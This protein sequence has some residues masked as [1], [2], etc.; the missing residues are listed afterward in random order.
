MEPPPA[1]GVR[2][3]IVFAACD[4]DMRGSVARLL[5][6]EYELEAVSDGQQ[7]LAAIDRR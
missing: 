1:G 3:R 4:Q 7:A 2:P 5:G 6:E